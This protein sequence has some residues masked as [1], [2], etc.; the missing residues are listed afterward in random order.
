MSAAKIEPEIKFEQALKVLEAITDKLNN[1]VEDLDE[2]LS[3]YEQGIHYMKLCREKLA[4]A[5]LK[6]EQLTERMHLEMP[7]GDE[8][9]Q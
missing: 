2:L 9:G 5:E 6:V 3:L 7:Q 1:G 4:D 8:N